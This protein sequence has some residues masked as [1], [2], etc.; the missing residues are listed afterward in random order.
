MSSGKS[1]LPVREPFAGGKLE[2][3]ELTI[4]IRRNNAQAL[5]RD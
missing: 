1:A 3:K 2:E 4:S 5:E